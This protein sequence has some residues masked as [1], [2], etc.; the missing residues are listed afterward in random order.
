[1]A[2]HDRNE[3]LA[4]CYWPDVKEGDLVALDQRA[5][6]A[7]DRSTRQGSEVRY[8]GSLLMREDEVVLCRF[9]GSEASVRRV[10]EWAAIPFERMLAAVHSPRRA[11]PPKWS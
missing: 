1:M 3:Y 7:A 9:Q 8:L 5:Q 6:I 10:A 11:R 4:E 2:S